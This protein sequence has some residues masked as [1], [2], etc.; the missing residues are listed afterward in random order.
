MTRAIT[1]VPLLTLVYALALESFKLWD[2]ALGA[3]ISAALLAATWRY[4]FEEPPVV[5]PGLLKRVLA[6][7]PFALVVLGDVLF[8]TW[9]VALVSLRLR[10]LPPS[11]IVAVPIGERSPTGVAVCTLVTTISPGSI[12]VDLDEE[13]GELFFHVMDA[14]NPEAVR[15]QYRQ[16]YERYQRHIFP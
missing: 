1:I 13:R 7:V 10:P 6:F 12:F 9:H 5:Q 14:S 3:L 16:F 15:E 11:G 8:G 2:L 4:L